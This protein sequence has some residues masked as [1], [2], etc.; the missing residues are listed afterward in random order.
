M[1]TEGDAITQPFQLA[2]GG[3]LSLSSG[4]AVPVPA[5]RLLVA[6]SVEGAARTLLLDTGATFSVLSEELVA[7]LARDG[8]G[9]LQ[10]DVAARGGAVR[11][12]LLR[13]RE[14]RALGVTRTG[15]SVSGFSAQVLA[16]VSAEVG[17]RVDGLLV[18]EFFLGF[19]TTINDPR[20][21]VELRRYRD[22][23]HARDP[24][25]RVGV[26][27][28]SRDGQVWEVAQVFPGT[29]AAR[30]GIT[31]GAVVRAIDGRPLTG[32]RRDDVD[33]LLVGDAGATRTIET[34]AQRYTVRVEDLIP[35]R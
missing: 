8:R 7:D 19:L 34:D 5:T 1:E 29:D 4:E 24:W 28:G 31:V 26:L 11:L 16:Q 23:S 3:S 27:L 14:L 22:L 15:V 20:G 32:L 13:V 12:T 18:A 25:T 17:A 30:Q 10:V 35:L 9:S 21:Q 6:A 33:T 2:G